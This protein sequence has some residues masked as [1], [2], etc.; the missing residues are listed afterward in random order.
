MSIKQSFVEGPKVA[1]FGREPA[2]WVGLL[3]S[4]L[5]ALLAFGIGITP[6]TYGPWMAVVVALGGLTT[7]W[8]T[9]DVGLSVIVGLLKALVVLVG[10]YGITLTDAQV[11][12]LIMIASAV[13]AFVTR[14]RTTPAAA[15]VTPSPQQVQESPLP[16]PTDVVTP[17]QELAGA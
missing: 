2:L 8:L 9:R 7:A 16:P 12:G 15:P 10:V 6:E 3:E 5:A 1:I 13:F 14:D 11:G 4:V 17:G